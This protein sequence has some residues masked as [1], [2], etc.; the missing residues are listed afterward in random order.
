MEV[1]GKCKDDEHGTT[2]I[3]FPDAEIFST[4]NFDFAVL[5]KRLQEIAFL[6]AGLKIFLEEESS[7]KKEEFYYAGGLIEFIQHITHSKMPLHKPIYFKKQQDTTV[8]EVAIQ[9]TENYN[10]NIFG[11]VVQYV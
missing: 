6:N 8:I 5:K 11:F 9:Y 10:E 7:E 2:V 3:F 4:L 1:V